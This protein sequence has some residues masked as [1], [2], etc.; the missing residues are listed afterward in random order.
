MP[1]GRVWPSVSSH[2]KS[3][4]PASK[5]YPR[6]SGWEDS[7]NGKR[8]ESKKDVEKKDVQEIGG[9]NLITTA[10]IKEGKYANI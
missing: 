8:K 1:P 4:I 9:R 3:V 6:E 10:K 7:L 5:T 2:D